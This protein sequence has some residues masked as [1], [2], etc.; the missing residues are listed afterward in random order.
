MSNDAKIKAAVQE[1]LEVARKY[2]LGIHLVLAGRRSAEVRLRTPSWS[3]LEQV[4]DERGLA[5]RFRTRV[6]GN[7]ERRP[8]QDITDSVTVLRA[9]AESLGLGAVP[10]LELNKQVS[11][12]L[13]A[14]AD[15]HF[16]GGTP[17]WDIT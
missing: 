4:E 3:C 13:G 1:I 10:L 7:G 14:E 16:L 5:I 17:A 2:D 9:I 11:E 6:G 12:K 8:Q 15:D